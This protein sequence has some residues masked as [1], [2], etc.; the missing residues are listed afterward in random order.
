[1]E[2]FF[3]ITLT[4]EKL[5]LRLFEEYLPK[6]LTSPSFYEIFIFTGFPPFSNKL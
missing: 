3:I 1:M 4:A 6:A 5:R 2:G